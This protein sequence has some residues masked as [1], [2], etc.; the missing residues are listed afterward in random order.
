MIIDPFWIFFVYYNEH[1]TRLY[2]QG[3]V[4]FITSNNIRANV[5]KYFRKFSEL[6][7]DILLL[8]QDC[9]TIAK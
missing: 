3:T 5:E 9:K 7:M 2:K 6:E 8:V 4:D 1:E